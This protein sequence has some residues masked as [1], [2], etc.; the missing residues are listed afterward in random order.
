LDSS[1][2]QNQSTEIKSI[3]LNENVRKK[4]VIFEL[5]NTIKKGAMLALDYSSQGLSATMY[6]RSL[7]GWDGTR[8]YEIKVPTLVLTSLED[9]SV[10][11]RIEIHHGTLGGANT[12]TRGMPVTPWR[13]DVVAVPR[14]TYSLSFE[15]A[16]YREYAQNNWYDSVSIILN[17]HL[18]LNK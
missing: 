9:N 4:D 8:S 6:S 10:P 15:A 2:N 13:S 17:T 1:T 3:E 16:A 5:G 14:G 7:R 18:T 12:S 11:I